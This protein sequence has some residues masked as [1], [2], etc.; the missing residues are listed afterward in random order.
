MSRG[1]RETHLV[2]V[3]EDGLL[4]ALVLDNLTEDTTVA[5]TDDE[6][7]LGVGVRVHGQV[8]DHL[9]VRELVALGGLD[10]IV[11]HQDVA[12]VGRLEDQDVLV[13]ALLM[14]QHLL[15]PE[16]HGLAWHGV[17]P[18]VS[19]KGACMLFTYRATS[20]RS[21]GT[22]HLFTHPAWSANVLDQAIR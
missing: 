5:A 8:G 13:L 10:D 7:L 4:D 19:A 3:A 20:P 18:G 17:S 22:S 21:H 6:H 9:L 12:V 11:Q 16:G 14:V 2:N 15:D 1:K